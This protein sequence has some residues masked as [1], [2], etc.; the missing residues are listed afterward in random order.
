MGVALQHTKEPSGFIYYVRRHW[1]CD[2]N[3]ADIDLDFTTKGVLDKKKC[4]FF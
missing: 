4:D 1:V 2:S 3:I